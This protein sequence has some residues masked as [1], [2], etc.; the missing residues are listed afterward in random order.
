LNDLLT[1]IREK[2]GLSVI[3]IPTRLD[4]IL[5]FGRYVVLVGV[6]YATIVTT[7]LWFSSYDPYRTIF[8]LGWLF[9]FNLAEHWPA[10]LIALGVIGGGLFI[11]RFW[12]RYLCPQGV[13]LGLIQ[14]ISVIKIWRDPA[15]CI[16]CGRCDRVCPSKLD[17]AAADAVRGDCIGCLE[18]IEAC[19]KAGA[20]TVGVGRSQPSDTIVRETA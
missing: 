20:L 4:Q 13:L 18:C 6:T 16:D 14:R 11:P 5:T 2:L 15:L 9:E 12:C 17:V 8:S 3:E 1:W 7:K 10:Y 19:P